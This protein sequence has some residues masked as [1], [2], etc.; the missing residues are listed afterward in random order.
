VKLR[1]SP[2]GTP[3][4][5]LL[6]FSLLAVAVTAASWL[7]TSQKHTTFRVSWPTAVGDSS[8]HSRDSPLPTLSLGQH[9][10]A[11]IPASEPI[12]KRR[13]DRMFAAN[14]PGNPIRL[15]T[16]TEKFPANQT[17]QLYLKSADGEFLRVNLETIAWSQPP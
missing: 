7:S 1:N 3:G 13:D 12:L 8:F 2:R 15:Y 11:I 4:R 14:L 10:F 9:Q 17:P 6:L 5:V 16:T